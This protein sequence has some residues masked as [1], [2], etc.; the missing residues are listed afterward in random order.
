MDMM[1]NGIPVDCTSNDF[2]S[3]ATCS[4]FG[5]GEVQT[6]QRTDEADIFKFSLLGGVS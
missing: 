6:I 4:V 1:F 5:S 3:K 2:N